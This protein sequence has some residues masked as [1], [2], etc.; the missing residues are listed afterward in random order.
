VEQ[1]VDVPMV[2]YNVDIPLLKE[3]MAGE[4]PPLVNRRSGNVLPENKSV[5]SCVDFL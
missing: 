3:Q 2:E 5:A 4:V 1:V